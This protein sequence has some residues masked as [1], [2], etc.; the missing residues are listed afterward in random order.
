M[1][2]LPLTE[3]LSI[4][5]ATLRPCHIRGTCALTTLC[6]LCPLCRQWLNLLQ[7]TLPPSPLQRLL[8]NYN[9]M[10]SLELIH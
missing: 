10:V 1:Q 2:I 8:G 4:Y 9:S 7:I 6:L 5:V 3:W